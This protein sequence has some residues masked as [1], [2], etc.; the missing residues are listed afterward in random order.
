MRM[1]LPL[2]CLYQNEKNID[3]FY[4]TLSDISVSVEKSQVSLYSELF[5]VWGG[6]S[7]K[8]WR[9]KGRTSDDLAD[10]EV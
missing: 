9:I 1:L 3:S 10:T 2:I 7:G 4:K 5:S 6:S 8:I